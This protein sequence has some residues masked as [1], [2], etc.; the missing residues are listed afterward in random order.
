MRAETLARRVA[1][2][3]RRTKRMVS[4]DRQNLFKHTYEKFPF[5]FELIFDV[6]QVIRLNELQNTA[7]VLVYT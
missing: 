1:L 6:I 5:M 4:G 3:E 2:Q 7:T